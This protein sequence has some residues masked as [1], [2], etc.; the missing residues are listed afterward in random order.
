MILY[1]IHFEDAEIY[2]CSNLSGQED[3]RPL[4]TERN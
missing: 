1:G 4:F 3:T 2:G